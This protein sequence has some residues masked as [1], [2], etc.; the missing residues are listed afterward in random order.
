MKKKQDKIVGIIL[1]VIAL[2]TIIIGM[3]TIYV[4]IISEI[5]LIPFLLW[6]ILGSG[7]YYTWRGFER[8][9]I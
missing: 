4:P 6:V 1:L 8:L 2:L 3:A 5:L 7:I 9:P